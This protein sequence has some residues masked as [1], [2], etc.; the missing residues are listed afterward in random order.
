MNDCPP[1]AHATVLPPLL[2]WTIARR[3]RTNTTLHGLVY[4]G[5][6]SSVTGWFPL[7]LVQLNAMPRQGIPFESIV[8]VGIPR[9]PGV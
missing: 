9:V 1:A 5:E 8:T 4:S 3:S 6:A 2:Q 7:V